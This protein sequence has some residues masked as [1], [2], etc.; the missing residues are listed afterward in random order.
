MTIV[1]QLKSVQLDALREVANIGAGHA[2]TALSQMTDRRIFI[3]VPEVIGIQHD[4][5]AQRLALPDGQQ[6]VVVATSI[7]GDLTGKTA[8]TLGTGDAQRLCNCLLRRESTPE[9]QLDCTNESTLKEVG[10]ILAGAYLNAL[11]TF[12]GMMLLPSV[13]ELIN[14]DAWTFLGA[15]DGEDNNIVLCAATEFSFLEGESGH[16]LRSNFLHFPDKASVQA[17]LQAINLG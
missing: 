16:P 14:A 10:N 5:L 11:A 13:P 17:I 9:G 7:M 12:M 6:M 4:D 2:A 1:S 15:N 3:S 8:L